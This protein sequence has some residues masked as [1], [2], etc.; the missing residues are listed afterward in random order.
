[1]CCGGGADHR[2]NAE[3]ALTIPACTSS[4]AAE[5]TERKTKWSS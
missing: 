4:G 3:V 5:G 2:M 1:M